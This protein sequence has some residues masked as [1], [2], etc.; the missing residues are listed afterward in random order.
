MKK[1]TLIA[2]AFLFVFA[3]CKKDDCPA[4]EV[5]PNLAT[6][7]WNGN[8]VFTS[9]TYTWV[10]TFNTDG[11]IT[12]SFNSGAIPITGGS[13][14]KTPGSNTVY[15]YLTI[16]GNNWKGVGTLNTAANK[17]ENGTFTQ[18]TGGSQTAT[19]TLNKQ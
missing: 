9:I 1:I 14:N 13:W 19:F 6:T 16:G 18:L 7:T 5:S 15:M 17:I 11:T 12:G 8:L 3:S 10:Q 2:I 4:P